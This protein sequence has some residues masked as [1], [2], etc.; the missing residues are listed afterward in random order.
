MLM[1]DAPQYAGTG[2][3]N[4]TP[5][6][7]NFDADP[8]QQQMM[9]L[10]KALRGGLGQQQQQQQGGA[11]AMAG[12]VIPVNQSAGLSGISSGLDMGSKMMGMFK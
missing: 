2:T 1:T 5:Y 12:Q 6:A 11:P 4:N 9:A 7:G 10:A 8:K 3:V